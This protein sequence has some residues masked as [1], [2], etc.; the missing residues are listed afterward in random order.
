MLWNHYLA[1]TGHAM[2]K[3]LESGLHILEGVVGT[4]AT[5]KGGYELA[6]TIGPGLRAMAPYATA[7]ALL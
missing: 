7:A 3:G 5:L 4:A 2:Q 6:S 1:E